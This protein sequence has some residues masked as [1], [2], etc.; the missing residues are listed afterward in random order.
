VGQNPE[1]QGIVS[2][3]WTL[4]TRNIWKSMCDGYPCLSTLLYLELTKTQGDDNL[5]H[6]FVLFFSH[7]IVEV[8][9]HVFNPD[10]LRWEGPSFIWAIPSAVSH[11]KDMEEGHALFACLPSL[12]LASDSFSGI[13]ACFFGIPVY[14]EN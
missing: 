5:Q 11:I 7:S 1:G 12:L 8:E 9:R 4:L 14:T 2:G 10:L 3:L 6:S 13:R